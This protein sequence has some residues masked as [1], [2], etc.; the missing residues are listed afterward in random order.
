MKVMNVWVIA[1]G[2][3]LGLFLYNEIITPLERDLTYTINT[4]GPLLLHFCVDNW[5][6][7]VALIPVAGGVLLWSGVLNE[8]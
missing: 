5:K 2:V 3:A 7:I 4:V 6:T 8:S 1:I